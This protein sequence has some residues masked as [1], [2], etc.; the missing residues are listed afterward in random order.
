MY[1]ND[2]IPDQDIGGRLKI[3][4]HYKACLGAT[5][6]Y[7]F[8]LKVHAIGSFAFGDGHIGLIFSRSRRAVQLYFARGDDWTDEYM[9][10]ELPSSAY[11]VK[12]GFQK[13]SAKYFV[14]DT[15]EVRALL[16]RFAEA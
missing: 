12:V 5:G 10:E 2:H 1:H 15:V 8:G 13:T 4:S 7:I 11:T 16:E 14:Q 3:D 9:F 6:L